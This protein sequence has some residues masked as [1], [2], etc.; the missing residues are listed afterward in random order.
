MNYLRDGK[1]VMEAGGGWIEGEM[2]WGT[3]RGKGVD[4][5]REHGWEED[6]E[7]AAAI[8]LTIWVQQVVIGWTKTVIWFNLLQ[9]NSF[10]NQYI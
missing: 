8:D 7:S 2:K 6:G 10:I 5:R 1:M 4:W 9:L 3:G